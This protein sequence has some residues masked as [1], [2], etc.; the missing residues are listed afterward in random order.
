MLLWKKQGRKLGMLATRLFSFSNKCKIDL[1][2][3]LVLCHLNIFYL[4]FHLMTHPAPT[5]LDWAHLFFY[6]AYLIH[7][8]LCFFFYSPVSF[9]RL[10]GIL[11]LWMPMLQHS[12]A[13]RG[14][15][16]QMIVQSSCGPR[17]DATLYFVAF[18]AL[19]L[20]AVTDSV[21]GCY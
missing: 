9:G 21:S 12:C 3:C 13:T 4:A 6:L 19:V 15:P 1:K 20:L 18:V 17:L 7:T 5:P 14:L 10:E 16:A 11:L 2:K 8:R